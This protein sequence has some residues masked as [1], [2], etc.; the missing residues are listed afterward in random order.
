MDEKRES[1]LI[2]TKEKGNKCAVSLGVIFDAACG[3]TAHDPSLNA[4]TQ[5]IFDCPFLPR[6]LPLYLPLG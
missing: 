6:P 1:A 2:A 5:Q 4:A 3:Q